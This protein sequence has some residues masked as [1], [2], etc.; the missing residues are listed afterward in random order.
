MGKEAGG[1]AGLGTQ[2]LDRDE[3]PQRAV[4]SHRSSSPFFRSGESGDLGS[5]FLWFL[6]SL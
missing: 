6:C 4:E 1:G 2:E 5:T 3:T